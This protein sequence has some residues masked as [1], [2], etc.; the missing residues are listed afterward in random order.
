MIGRIVTL[1]RKNS[2]P[3][4]TQ[5]SPSECG[6]CVA[7]SLL[8]LYGRDEAV[9]EVR[10][11]LEPGRDGVTLRQISSFLA[12][13]GMTTRLAVLNEFEELRQLS[14]PVIVLWQRSH[15]IVVEDFDGDRALVMDP[16]VGRRTISAKEL[17]ENVS[18]SVLWVAPGETFQPRSRPLMDQWRSLGLER[19]WLLPRLG[20]ILFLILI[21]FATA[22]SVPEGTAWLVDNQDR[23][24]ETR[25]STV[26][27][28][29]FGLGVGFFLL[30]Y[31][32]AR[33]ISRLMA[34]I[35]EL[36]T[37]GV[38]AKLLRLP[39]NFFQSRETGELIYRLGSVDSVRNAL[40][41]SMAQGFFLSLI[42]I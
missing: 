4:V 31:L 37:D 34:E 18:K 26:F 36:L 7:A 14:A 41:L 42:H 3:V 38:L 40:A 15:F 25:S 1:A 27:L 22:L 5:I 23:W 8:R 11:E 32:T 28:A 39:Y 29:I 17:E 2:V 24:I 12:S 16:A 10:S 35:G 30:A 19:A 20:R 33:L 6:P 9:H 21:G 13:R